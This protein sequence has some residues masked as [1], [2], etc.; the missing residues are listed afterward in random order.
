MK[1]IDILLLEDFFR[2]T[3]IAKYYN[4]FN[5]TKHFNID[6]IQL[7]Q[8]RKLKNLL[9][10]VFQNVPWYRKF[11]QSHYDSY[12][13]FKRIEDLKHLP[14]LDREKI[15]D[16]HDEL[17]NNHYFGRTFMSSSSGTTGMPINYWHDINAYSA[18]IAS[19]YVLMG[20]SGWQPGDR[21]VHIWG[22]S[23]SIKQWNK[24]NSKIK[25]KIYRRKNISSRLINDPNNLKILVDN[26]KKFKPKVIDGYANSI[27]ELASY[28]NKDKDIIPGIKTIFTTAE[29][30]EKKHENI[31]E[32]SLA[33]VS[34]IYGCGEINGIACRPVKDNKYYILDS[35]V[36]VETIP[37]CN[38]GLKEILVTDL[39]N[40]YMPFIRYKVGDLIDDVQSAS[41]ENPLPFKYFTKIYGRTSDYVILPNGKKFYPVN[42]FGGTMFRKYPEIRRHKTIW[43]GEKIKFIFELDKSFDLTYLEA[44][45]KKM[46]SE[47]EIKFEIEITEKILPDKSGKFSYFEKV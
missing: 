40:Y 36:I 17:L 20:I 4:E 37:S 1:F 2:K 28:L 29:N 14:I 34:D 46:L 42:I 3:K 33:P 15:R 16:N 45:I 25:Q 19:G 31:I 39:D 7:L 35:H 43:D 21:T 41:R 12:N 5:Q 38:P 30:L 32:R 9:K 47:Y 23:D 24:L 27:F 10:D 8:F 26:I 6:K 44:E 13:E 11:S 18:G 22:N